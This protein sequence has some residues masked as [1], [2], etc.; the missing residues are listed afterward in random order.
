MMKRRIQT[1]AATVVMSLMASNCQQHQCAV[2]F[3]STSSIDPNIFQR[4]KRTVVS[5][6]GRRNAIS[7]HSTLL[8]EEEKLSPESIIDAVADKVENV[9]ELKEKN[10]LLDNIKEKIGTVDESRMAN[11]E[12]ASGEVPRIFRY[13]TMP[14]GV[15]HRTIFSSAFPL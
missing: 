8:D 7:V 12:F 11:T 13:V 15:Q 3:S 2:A 9:E 4:Q 14:A 1:S 10:W 5:R 6:T